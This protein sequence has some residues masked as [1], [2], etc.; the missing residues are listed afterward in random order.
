M[1]LNKLY[2]GNVEGKKVKKNAQ[3]HTLQFLAELFKCLQITFELWILDHLLQLNAIF[4]D[5]HNILTCKNVVYHLLI[6][7]HSN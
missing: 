2:V 5:M 6:T 3:V 1:V 7:M 4:N